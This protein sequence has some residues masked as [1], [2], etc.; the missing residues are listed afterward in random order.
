MKF[1]FDFSEADKAL[2]LEAKQ[3]L[4][5]EGVDRNLHS[6]IGYFSSWYAGCEMWI[7]LL[8]AKL[9]K[10]TDLYSFDLLTRGMDARTKIARLKRICE[11]R[12]WPIGRNFQLRLNLYEGQMTDLRNKLAHTYP[13]ADYK[14]RVVIF[15]MLGNIPAP[16]TDRHPNEEAISLDELFES[17]AWLQLFNIDLKSIADS[18]THPKTLEIKSPQT[19]LLPGQNQRRDSTK[20][21]T[22]PGRRDRKR[23]RKGQRPRGKQATQG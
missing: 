14:R 10:S 4:F 1:K 12:N 5:I 9:T 19:P 20:N 8:L 22:I 6:H 18:L 17:G 2:I 11:D 15:T 7:T 16:G 3:K 23:I 21:A 13:V